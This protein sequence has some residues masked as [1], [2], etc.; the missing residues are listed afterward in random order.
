MAL[1]LYVERCL[2][3]ALAS[4]RE[5]DLVEEV[6]GK[7]HGQKVTARATEKGIQVDGQSVKA[8][9]FDRRG[10]LFTQMAIVTREEGALR[11]LTYWRDEVVMALARGKGDVADHYTSQIHERVEQLFVVSEALADRGKDPRTFLQ[12]ARDWLR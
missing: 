9:V 3:P 7:V 5:L 1:P 10:P 6:E 12:R 2:F 8:V 4:F 11:D